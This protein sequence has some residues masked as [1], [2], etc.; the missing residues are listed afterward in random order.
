M[1][2]VL[3]EKTRALRADR[4]AAMAYPREAKPGEES[5]LSAGGEDRPPPVPVPAVLTLDDALRIASKANRD[6]LSRTE[7]LYLAGLALT[8]AR[9]Q[10]SPKVSS[11]LSYVTR[12]TNT[13]R[14]VDTASAKLAASQVLP[15]G[16]TVAAGASATG[17]L[18]RNADGKFA[19]G[20]ALTASLNQPLLKGAGYEASHE[21]LTLAEREVV[22]A[23][24]DF[25]RFREQF[26]VDVTRRFYDI[27]SQRTV[28]KNTEERYAAVQYQVRRAR[29]LFDI[30]KQDKIEVLRAENDELRVQNDLVNARDSLGLAIDQFKV[31]LGLPVSVK[32]EVADEEPTARKVD[33][34][35]DSA[36]SAA[37][38]N[39]FDLAN[40]REQLE[41]SERAL[42]IAR[43]NLLPDLSLRAGY[44]AASPSTTQLGEQAY[45][46]Q[47]N[48]IGLFLD[49]PLQQTVERNSLRAA[50]IA[51]D[52]QRRSFQEFRDNIVVEVRD[53]LRRLR[54][55]SV[56]LEIQAS[57]IKVGQKQ[58]EKAQIDFDS[59]R[60]G[61][62]DLLEAQQSLTDAKNV[63]V[64]LVVDYQIAWLNLERAMG[65]LEVEPDGS[66]RVLRAPA[67]A[68]GPGGAKGEGKP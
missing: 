44:D 31:F 67:P 46:T 10:F 55:A 4:Q 30:G 20:T 41:D 6:Y 5:S 19:A 61:N 27:L 21:S 38:S 52:R 13:T 3:G 11:T 53:T 60:I 50:Q 26:L 56:G 63:R 43:R 37:L 2:S 1:E 39:R 48:S 66:W 47:S 12:D 32:F 42:R 64:R 7:S 24:R 40:A 59:G 49:I 51:L 35:L 68:P 34:A 36:V 23:I 9:Y 28:L 29:A 65:T 57:I 14:N 58:Y 54:Q 15:T 25:S 8:A 17:N 18:D 45:R 16:G 22:Y 33:V 62:R